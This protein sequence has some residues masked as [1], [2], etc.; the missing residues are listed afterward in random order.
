M[1]GNDRIH[2]RIKTSHHG[3]LNVEC[4]KR[5]VTNKRMGSFGNRIANN[6]YLAY[7][8]LRYF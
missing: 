5:T 8:G 2:L 3:A 1:E 6:E 7:A 4:L